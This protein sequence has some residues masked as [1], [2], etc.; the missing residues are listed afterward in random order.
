MSCNSNARR[1]VTG[2]ARVDDKIK[3][4]RVELE[5]HLVAAVQGHHGG[6]SPLPGHNEVTEKTRRATH[7]R[8]RP[9]APVFASRR[10][11]PRNSIMKMPTVVSKVLSRFRTKQPGSIGEVIST[12]TEQATRDEQIRADLRQHRERLDALVAGG[13]DVTDATKLLLAERRQSRPAASA[14]AP[15]Q[16]KVSEL[17]AKL[18]TVRRDREEVLAARDEL[19]GDAEPV[20]PAPPQTTEPI[21]LQYEIDALGHRRLTPE[22]RAEVRRRMYNEIA[23]QTGTAPP[24]EAARP[25]TAPA[26]G[27]RGRDRAVSSINKG[28]GINASLSPVEK[29][30]NEE[31]TIAAA[32][33]SNPWLQNSA[34]TALR[35]G[36][37]VS[38]QG[39]IESALRLERDEIRSLPPGPS[40]ARRGE[41]LNAVCSKLGLSV[42]QFGIGADQHVA[43]AQPIRPTLN[44]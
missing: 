28:V 35:S 2:A 29:R 23:Q 19:T 43:A 41:V 6:V 10:S 33:R 34:L 32:F 17:E 30:A 24:P 4:N 15:A 25:R 13:M 14:P 21:E 5:R 37:G 18:A 11:S 36:A 42:R 16:S 27:L 20:E 9:G 22:C 39:A 1:N 8:S 31:V 26:S 3:P 40:R 12:L 38:V 7:R 44:T